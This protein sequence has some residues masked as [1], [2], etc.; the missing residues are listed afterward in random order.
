VALAKTIRSTV[1]RPVRW[2]L[3]RAGLDLVKAAPNGGAISAPDMDAK[4]LA[5]INAVQ[6]YTLTTPERIYGLIE[7]VRYLTRAGIQGDIVECGVWR[8][9]SM[10]AT[11]RTL[12]EEGDTSRHF[13][14]FDTF[15]RMPLPEDRDVDA[16]GTPAMD[17]FTTMD[18]D[19]HEHPAYKYLPFD[20]VKAAIAS[21]GYPM[22]KMTFVKGLVEDTIPAGAPEKIALLRLD[23]DWYRSTK[24]EME[25]LYPRIVDGGVLIV[26]DYGHFKGSKDAVDEY[27]AEHNE[28]ILLTRMDWSGRLAVVKR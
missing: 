24:H 26:D 15:E 19:P 16:S 22:D 3:R 6:W 7:A 12:V 14:L 28:H 8:G 21:S 2:T 23:T 20:E 11:A 13:H 1:G 27:L 9:G 18:I 5:T 25:H 17:Y 4:A 10:M